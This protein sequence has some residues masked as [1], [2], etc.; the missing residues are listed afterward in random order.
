LLKEFRDAYLISSRPGR[1]LVNT[2]YRYSP[3]IAAY[4]SEHDVPRAL[5]RMGLV[6]LVAASHAVL[7]LGPVI[8]ITTFY[9]FVVVLLALFR[10]R[11][12]GRR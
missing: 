1:K 11:Q 10:V 12:S 7:K 6:P 9:A 4:I 2:C 3:R 8:I 5:V